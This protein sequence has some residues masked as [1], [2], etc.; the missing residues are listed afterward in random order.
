M[1]YLDWRKIDADKHYKFFWFEAA[2]VRFLVGIS[3]KFSFFY[4]FYM[5]IIPV[6][7]MNPTTILLRKKLLSKTFLI[8]FFGYLTNGIL[9][10]INY[11]KQ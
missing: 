3:L 5:L 2:K 11:F 7:I 4:V 6:L 1:N 8:S 9:D 10:T